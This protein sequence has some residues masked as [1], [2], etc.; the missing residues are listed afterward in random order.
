M[1]IYNSLFLITL[2]LVALEVDNTRNPKLRISPI[3]GSKIMNKQWI[4]VFL[5]LLLFA[6]L[7]T[8]VG[9]TP[10]YIDTFNAAS[11]KFTLKDLDTRGVLFFGLMRFRKAFIFKDPQLWLIVLA[12]LALLPYVKALKFFSCDVLMS[13]FLFF[14]TAQ[15]VYF[16]SGARQ[17]IA[18]AICFYA[19]RYLVEKKTWKYLLL[20][21]LAMGFHVTAV[22]M[23]VLP[24]VV[25][26]KPWSQRMWLLIVIA[27]V[28]IM[29]SETLFKNLGNLVLANTA[30]DR[31]VE[32]ALNQKGVT[33]SRAL[34]AVV[35][36]LLCFVYR[37]K[38]KA[39]EDR[40]LNIF[41]NISMINA[42]WMIAATGFGGD[43]TGR[44]SEYFSTINVVPYPCIFQ[45]LISDRIRKVMKACF[46][47]GYGLFYIY[48]MYIAWG[49]L[50]YESKILKIFL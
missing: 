25:E 9:D 14:A 38:Q 7:R 28:L 23:L 49:G 32:R 17:M 47:L 33:I 45:K 26:I 2:F 29:A 10:S 39:L 18:V 44:I 46:V 50:N 15:F 36:I 3:E 13:V 11:C 43:L 1:L 48:Q 5:P 35:P 37:G 31:Y 24:L 40:T 30:Y 34:V 27:I 21:V 8:A 12:L 20:V 19:V 41:F 42:C 22:V 4:I 6:M 16:F